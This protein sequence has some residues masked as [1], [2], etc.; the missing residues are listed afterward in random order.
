YQRTLLAQELLLGRLDIGYFADNPYLFVTAED[1]TRNFDQAGSAFARILLGSLLVMLLLCMILYFFIHHVIRRLQFLAGVLPVIGA[2]QF[3]QAEKL[4]E[5]SR[6]A[7]HVRQDELDF[8]HQSVR[9][10]NGRLM[11]LHTS[12]RS[13]NDQL[14]VL[15]DFDGMTGL[16]NRRRFRQELE[17]WRREGRPFY[18]AL[19]DLDHFKVINDT[20]GHAAGDH[21]LA[22]FSDV[23]REEVSGEG[24]LLARM[25]GDE[26]AMAMRGNSRA[27]VEAL[28]GRIVRLWLQSP[29]WSR[30]LRMVVKS[31]PSIGVA[32]F[33]A[34]SGNMEELL[35]CA[36]TAMYEN[37]R[38]K[39]ADFHFYTGRELIVFQE[40]QLTNWLN[41][42]TQ[43]FQQERF[44]VY[45][46]PIVSQTGHARVA[47]E[48][49]VRIRCQEQD[50]GVLHAGHFIAYAEQTNLI[51]RIDRLV[52]DQ[53]LACLCSHQPQPV[54]FFNVS[55]NTLSTPG[56]DAYILDKLEEYGYDPACLVIELTESAEIVNFR[57]AES[58]INGLRHAGIRFALDDFGTGFSSFNYIS[59]LELDFI[60]IDKSI[61]WGLLAASEYTK[62]RGIVE[63]IVYLARAAGMQVIL[64][65][66]ET[67]EVLERI[68]GLG[69]D[70]LQGY[71]FGQPSASI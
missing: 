61:V 7:T 40:R 62:N 42:L 48:A 64:E 67:P 39:Q 2:G 4:L 66:V 50:G 29:L 32:G 70:L 31:K 30:G 26:F 57:Q 37:K 8:M 11:Q 23:L 20:L 63:S 41:H 13:Q 68:E 35:V 55:N 65:G 6:P 38:L 46:Q 16:W 71:L 12:L 25:G 47:C 53:A 56:F 21:V 59:K 27:E 69:A 14:R 44:L 22:A 18:L 24:L 28:L 36:D 19:F 43:A 52:L 58:F 17:S 49:L 45:F 51:V 10:L 34:D 15:A 33:P 1:M 60:K 3:E 5:R 54:L 9:V